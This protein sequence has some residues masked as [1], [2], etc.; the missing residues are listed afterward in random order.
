MAG[1]SYAPLSHVP[2][3]GFSTDWKASGYKS[4]VYE[5]VSV[6]VWLLSNAAGGYQWS[7]TE[8]QDTEHAILSIRSASFILCKILTVYIA[9]SCGY[10]LTKV[11]LMLRRSWLHS[12]QKIGRDHPDAVGSHGWFPKW[13]RVPQSHID[14]SSQYGSKSSALAK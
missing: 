7:P 9:V 12:R 8:L 10:T 14:C 11:M 6:C 13:S 5:N 1:M 4:S 2:L 3:V